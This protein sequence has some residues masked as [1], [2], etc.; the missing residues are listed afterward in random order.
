MSQHLV[1]G[2]WSGHRKIPVSVVGETPDGFQ[3]VALKQVFL[4]GHGMLK[5]GQLSLV[6]KGVVRI[7]AANSHADAAIPSNDR[8]D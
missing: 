8:A 2:G 3:I 5:K 1:I 7:E 6:P 4:P